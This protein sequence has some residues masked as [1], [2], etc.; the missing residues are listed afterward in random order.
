VLLYVNRA[1]SQFTK[2]VFGAFGR[3]DSVLESECIGVGEA[4]NEVEA[5]AGARTLLHNV[6]AHECFLGGTTNR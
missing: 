5:A 3:T 2:K 1:K 4:R 6:L